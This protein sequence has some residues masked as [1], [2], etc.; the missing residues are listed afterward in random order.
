MKLSYM[1]HTCK[2]RSIFIKSKSTR[3][4]FFTL[5]FKTSTVHCFFNLT[6]RF[7]LSNS[8]VKL[9]TVFVKL[10]TRSI[11][12][13]CSSIKG[14]EYC[15]CLY[16]NN[17]YPY[18]ILS[19]ITISSPFVSIRFVSCD[20]RIVSSLPDTQSFPVWFA[21]HACLTEGSFALPIY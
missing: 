14:C 10:T 12:L 7:V 20:D 3:V 18:R 16:F 4:I 1:Y 9:A 17:Y 6:K 8:F 13:L 5:L 15:E 21:V 2:Y 19:K 11:P